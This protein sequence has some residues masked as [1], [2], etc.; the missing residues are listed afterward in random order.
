MF[1][2]KAIGKTIAVAVA[3]VIAIAAIAGAYIFLVMPPPTGGETFKIGVT[4]PLTGP[5][6]ADADLWL[7]G[8]TMAVNHYNEM[9]GI[10]GKNV[11]LVVYDD[12]FA[13]DKIGP[14]YEKLITEDKA[15]ILLTAMEYDAPSAAVCKKYNKVMVHWFGHGKELHDNYGDRIVGFYAHPT[16][17]AAVWGV[18]LGD[19]MDNFD[20]WNTDPTVQK[21]KTWA[22]ILINTPYGIDQAEHLP[23][24][25]EARGFDVI[26]VEK[27]QVGMSDWTPVIAKI[28]SLKPDVVA[29]YIYYQDAILMTRQ[30]KEQDVQLKWYYQENA[31]Y[32]E[33]ILPGVGIGPEVGNNVF[34]C[35][36]NPAK[37]HSGDADY[38]R[39]TWKNKYGTD[40]TYMAIIGYNA[41][42]VIKRGADVAKST[43][44]WDILHALQENTVEISSM[45]VKIDSKGYNEL[46]AAS[47]GQWQN[48]KYETVWVPWDPSLVSALPSSK[49][50]P[51]Q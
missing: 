40:L 8:M 25:L 9:G 2:K 24:Y 30:L 10:Q 20:V 4:L 22:L 29:C 45:K 7:K 13:E 1:G 49:G 44:E 50:W 37:W 41:I 3:L 26:L 35:D 19:M 48:S 27:T 11:S 42:E 34:G 14:L 31:A 43:N 33:W 39:D 47:V 38:L 32:S 6:A 28:Q 51:A 36:L 18:D 15:D 16:L 12:G 46:A 23:P 21:P 17:G 5:I